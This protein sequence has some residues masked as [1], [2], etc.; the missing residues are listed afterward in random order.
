M[1]KLYFFTLGCICTVMLISTISVFAEQAENIV[2][3]F[4]KVSLVVNGEKIDKETLLYNGTTYIPLRATAEVLGKEVTWNPDNNTAY[5]EDKLTAQED[6]NGLGLTYF[7][8][9]SYGYFSDELLEKY[10]SVNE[11]ILDANQSKVV[12]ITNKAYK[13]F[14]FFNVGYKE[15]DGEFEFYQKDIL[16]SIDEWTPE[17]PIVVSTIIAEGIPARGIS[18]VNEQGIKEFYLITWSG[19]DDSIGLIKF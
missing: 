17:V 10:N 1:K 5:I 13:D 6:K 19:I 8:D 4:N 3:I 16:F 18:F 9:I 12:F 14:N 2:A 7:G 11:K 15:I